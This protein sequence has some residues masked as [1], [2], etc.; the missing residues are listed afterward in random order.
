MWNPQSIFRSFIQTTLMPPGTSQ[1]PCVWFFF[2]LVVYHYFLLYFHG[3]ED[4][5][6]EPYLTTRIR[7][8][9]LARLAHRTFMHMLTIHFSLGYGWRTMCGSHN[10]QIGQ[11]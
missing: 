5:V 9:P 11:T 3:N 10:M 2:F 4:L 8:L 6:V 7:R 1:A